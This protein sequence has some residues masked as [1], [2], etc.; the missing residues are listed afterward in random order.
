M[1]F[2]IV[3]FSSE[4]IITETWLLEGVFVCFMK[5]HRIG[6]DAMRYGLSNSMTEHYVPNQTI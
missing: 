6:Y 5:V 4:N 3:Q 1:I 2:E